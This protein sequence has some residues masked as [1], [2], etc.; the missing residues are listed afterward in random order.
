MCN[1]HIHAGHAEK[2]RDVSCN[3]QQ[4]IHWVQQHGL[5]EKLLGGF[6]LHFA[7]L[8]EMHLRCRLLAS[9]CVLNSEDQI[10]KVSE[11]GSQ[12]AGMQVQTLST[13]SGSGT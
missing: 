11:Q 1:H 6:G 2:V 9:I 13:H 3:L 4:E 5:L 8:A 7:S 10:N 12:L